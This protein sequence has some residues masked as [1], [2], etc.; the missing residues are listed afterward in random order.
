[1]RYFEAQGCGGNNKITRKGKRQ[2]EECDDDASTRPASDDDLIKIGVSVS[3]RFSS[4]APGNSTNRYAKAR[5]P[6]NGNLPGVLTY[7]GIQRDGRCLIFPSFLLHPFLIFNLEETL[8]RLTR[9]WPRESGL[10]RAFARI[11]AAGV[12][13]SLTARDL[14]RLRESQRNP[15]RAHRED[16]ERRLL[17]DRQFPMHSAALGSY[18]EDGLT[19]PRRLDRRERRPDEFAF[20][21]CKAQLQQIRED[22]QHGSGN[23]TVE[24]MREWQLSLSLSLSLRERVRAD[25]SSLSRGMPGV[26]ARVVHQGVITRS[27]TAHI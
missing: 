11:R 1:V 12:S 27:V 23:D 14:R 5:A 19:T 13:G 3:E 18:Q 21:D 22:K 16:T 17:L 6:L 10:R 15:R 4:G 20:S 2:G 8:T 26:C 9:G 7:H 25:R 24:G